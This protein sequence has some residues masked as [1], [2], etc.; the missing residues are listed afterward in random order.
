[1]IYTHSMMQKTV[2]GLK[3]Q[4][5]VIVIIL[6]YINFVLWFINVTG[7]IILY[8]HS[9]FTLF[10]LKKEFLHVTMQYP[11][12]CKSRISHSRND[13]LYVFAHYFIFDVYFMDCGTTDL[14]LCVWRLYSVVSKKESNFHFINFPIFNFHVLFGFHNISIV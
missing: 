14:N 1:M 12:L 13:K 11:I 6:F 7:S 4:K 10:S 2:Y 9:P 8:F 5:N 3:C